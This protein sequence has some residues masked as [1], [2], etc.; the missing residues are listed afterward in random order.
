MRRVV[1]TGFGIVCSIGNNVKLFFDGISNHL[2]GIDKIT[3]FD[4]ENLDVH[5]AAEVKNIETHR[6]DRKIDFALYAAQEAMEMAKEKEFNTTTLLHIG[7]SL[8]T[9]DFSALYSLPNLDNIDISLLS[10]YQNQRIPLDT[11]GRL[12][13]AQYGN[14][15]LFLNNVS[16]C[17]IGTQ[18]IGHA[19]HAIRSGQYDKALAGGFDSMLNPIGLG[20]FQKLGA[21]S[22]DGC[23]PFDSRRAGLVL[24]EGAAMIFLES[25]ES[26]INRR[27]K[28]Y[29]EVCGYGASLDAYSLSAPS[30]DGTYKM[31]NGS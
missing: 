29:A 28:I 18:T 24:G 13:I 5:I 16:A 6:V 22:P 1:V 7:S 12:L 21:L 19:F 14:P 11:A 20:G 3:L 2:C 26:A 30:E 31:E 15:R 8:E 9:V 25:L 4:T 23:F 17:A 10:K 27:K